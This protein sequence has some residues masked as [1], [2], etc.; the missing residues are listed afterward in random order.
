ME[1]FAE[2]GA[3]RWSRS[4]QLSLTQL[5][6]RSEEAFALRRNDVRESE[7]VIDEALVNGHTKEPKTLASASSV[8]VPSDLMTE[9]RHYL[10]TIDPIPTAWL[11][12]SSRN[13]FLCGPAIF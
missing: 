2:G 1:E 4:S 3:S 11:F 9:L 5:G 13:T 6:L 12:P 7:L 10:E 8:Y